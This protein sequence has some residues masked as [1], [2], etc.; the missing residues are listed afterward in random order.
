MSTVENHTESAMSVTKMK[1]PRLTKKQA[2]MQDTVS[3]L[4]RYMN[5]YTEQT[6]YMDY[7]DV[8]YIN[9]VLY[10]LGISLDDELF[11]GGYGFARFKEFLRAHLGPALRRGESQ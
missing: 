6:G 8:T 10:G 7:E 4:Q 2:R 5:T 1:G 9:D 3:R 11:C